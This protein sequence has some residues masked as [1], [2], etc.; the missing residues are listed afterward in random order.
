MTITEMI[1]SRV[2]EM[3]SDKNMVVASLPSPSKPAKKAIIDCGGRH[4][5]DGY[6][7]W[8]NSNTCNHYSHDPGQSW[9]DFEVPASWVD[10]AQSAGNDIWKYPDGDGETTYSPCIV[11]PDDGVNPPRLV[12]S[13]GERHFSNGSYLCEMRVHALEAYDFLQWQKQNDR[14]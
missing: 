13:G 12:Y 1:R 7:T 2:E 9:S 3:R 6:D 8:C 4:L 11:L 10:E 14:A 5:Q